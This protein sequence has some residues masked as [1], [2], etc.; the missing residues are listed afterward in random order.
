MFGLNTGI[1]YLV[2]KVIKF[3]NVSSDEGVNKVST[4][5]KL[6]NYSVLGLLTL[7][8][9]LLENV[10]YSIFKNIIGDHRNEI[11]VR[12]YFILSKMRGTFLSL[13]GIIVFIIFIT[14]KRVSTR[15]KE[16]FGRMCVNLNNTTILQ[17]PNKDG[18]NDI[19][20]D[21]FNINDIRDD[22]E[23]E[24]IVPHDDDD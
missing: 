11:I 7:I 19:S 12:L 6:F 8:F 2:T 10:Y 23:E 1:A 4:K 15:I 3:I 9:N 20:L 17:V 14:N 13:R 24:K 21:S 5:N 18:E 22:D 16:F